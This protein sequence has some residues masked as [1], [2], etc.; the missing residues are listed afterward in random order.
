MPQC[1]IYADFNVKTQQK[2]NIST[3]Y[4]FL[5]GDILTIIPKYFKT[6]TL[7]FENRGNGEKKN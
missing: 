1:Y 4:F 6:K 5:S 7:I 2:R 3:D